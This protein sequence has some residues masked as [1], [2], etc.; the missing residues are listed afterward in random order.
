MGASILPRNPGLPRGKLEDRP[1]M[2]ADIRALE[3]PGLD[4][5][6][7]ADEVLPGDGFLA[8]LADRRPVGELRGIHGVIVRREGAGGKK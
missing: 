6:L 7:A 1:A 5:P 4:L 8:R 3:D 2:G